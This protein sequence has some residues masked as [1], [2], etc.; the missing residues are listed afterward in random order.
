MRRPGL[1]ITGLI[2]GLTL[3]VSTISCAQEETQGE[4]AEKESEITLNPRLKIQTTLGDF[5]LELDGEKAP[6]STLNFIRY[7]EDGFYNG[8]VF[9]RVI[10]N[11][12]IQGGGFNVAMDQ[13]TDGLRAPIKNE[14]RNGL[15]NDRGTI[16]MARTGEPDSATAQFFINV[17]DNASL[18]RAS[19]GAAYAVFGKVVEGMETVEKIRNTKVFQHPKYPQGAVTPV[20]P[21][22]IQTITLLNE[23][24]REGLEAQVNPAAT[25]KERELQDLIAK[26][27]T[28][29]K[30]K[31][32]K[33]S[34]GL[35]ILTLKEGDGASPKPTETVE[36]HYTG[37]LIDGTKF[38]SS[39]DR[40]ESISFPL[41]DVI[42]GWTEGVG[43][44]KVGGTSK[45][46]IP[47]ELGYGSQGSPGTI[48]PN[49]FLHFEIELISIQ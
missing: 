45:L 42:A 8:T 48:P 31:F 40:G 36:V 18:D 38:D 12:M 35:M 46:I 20:E 26:I 14:W 17:V 11:F 30:K 3:A 32:T 27:E 44:M 19:G 2:A 37:W 49:A 47:P 6:I 10:P 24:D 7:A 9:H 28:E 43:L 39:H 21:V 25:A 15:K 34:S 5:V 13:K 29:T 41:N 16:A 1:L 4:T 22:V 23:F 33:T